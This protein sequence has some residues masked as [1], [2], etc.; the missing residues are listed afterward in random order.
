M[1]FEEQIA[2]EEQPFSGGVE[3]ILSPKS[4][5]VYI[6]D[7]GSVL[8]YLPKS[9]G[10]VSLGDTIS[11]W[12]RKEP[13]GFFLVRGTVIPSG[14]KVIPNETLSLI[15]PSLQKL[16][17]TNYGPLWREKVSR[18]PY[19]ALRSIGL[20]IEEA[21]QIL[22]SLGIEEDAPIRA[23]AWTEDLIRRYALA[24][25]DTVC[26]LPDLM[27]A[28]GDKVYLIQ[29]AVF[30]NKK[31]VSLDEGISLRE[32]VEL[33]DVILQNFFV[34][35]NTSPPK[36]LQP[37]APLWLQDIWADLNERGFSFLNVPLRKERQIGEEIATHL[38]A[39][40]LNA[41]NGKVV[42]KGSGVWVVYRASLLN[43]AETATLVQNLP[44]EPLVFI[45]DVGILP[46]T[47]GYGQ[48]FRPFWEE[49]GR[50]YLPN[51]IGVAIS[52]GEIPAPLRELPKIID[53][54][55]FKGRVVVPDRTGD[56]GMEGLRKR[57]IRASTL[58]LSTPGLRANVLLPLK[59][60]WA[61]SSWIYTALNY[62]AHPIFFIEEGALEAALRRPPPR[63]RGTLEERIRLIRLVQQY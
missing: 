16:M 4:L 52:Q 35:R 46:P 33:E 58:H 15:P 3:E 12:V 23:T 49:T 8:V 57:G 50:R 10:K 60:R 39:T 21:D 42:R 17:E 13:Y 63:P 38:N 62:F 37:Y 1:F 20:S 5:R 43:L 55:T 61:N 44:P 32:W 24:T 27:A 59:S 14:E 28:A 9:F 2:K 26:P 29:I 47:G 30:D 53:S 25:G 31:F 36:R 6:K 54:S 51:P 7:R 56:M 45:G 48:P 34:K 22:M 11:G 19:Q 18:E 40:L 41:K